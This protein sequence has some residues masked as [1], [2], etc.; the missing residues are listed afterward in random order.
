MYVEG[1]GQKSGPCTATFNDLL[2]KLFLRY[3][4]STILLYA[5][6]AGLAYI[7]FLCSFFF[8]AVC[9]CSECFCGC[10][11]YYIGGRVCVL[12]TGFYFLQYSDYWVMCITL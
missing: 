1:V 10:F 6:V 9:S 3:Y 11:S 7:L 8:V 12:L 4:A 5:R 2:L